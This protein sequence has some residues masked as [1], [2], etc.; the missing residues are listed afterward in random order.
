M[1]GGVV[2]RAALGL[3]RIGARCGERA[4]NATKLQVE[5]RRVPCGVQRHDP[6]EVG[7]PPLRHGE[8]FAT[9]GR[10]ADKVEA[11]G[12]VNA[13]EVTHQRKGHVAGFLERIA[14]KIA[15]RFVVD[16]K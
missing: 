7:G 9:T 3:V 4:R 15:H 5:H 10:S 6:V 12:I 14:R 1:H 11:A 2:Q 13:I 8:R 16:A